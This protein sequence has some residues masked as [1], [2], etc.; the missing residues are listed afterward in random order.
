MER[1]VEE[2]RD[3]VAS[4]H[5]SRRGDLR[6]GGGG[7]RAVGSSSMPACRLKR[8]GGACQIGGA[9]LCPARMPR[10]HT[11]AGK[12]ALLPFTPKGLI[13]PT[14][15][16]LNKK[17]Q[18]PTRL[19]MHSLEEGPGDGHPLLLTA[20]QLEPALAHHCLPP[21]AR[22]RS[23]HSGPWQRQTRRETMK[24]G[25][26]IKYLNEHTNATL[27]NGTALALHDISSSTLLAS[28]SQCGAVTK[29]LCPTHR[30]THPGACVRWPR[31]AGRRRPPPAPP[32]SLR[33]AGRRPRCGKWCHGTARCP[34]G[35]RACACMCW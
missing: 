12:E 33:P 14:A 1:S 6:P 8:A 9:K 3:E 10:Q 2:S 20:T 27:Q 7:A 17:T 30:A 35:K 4:S 15:N 23:R 5:T 31:P 22:A 29:A 34:T 25:V 21:C 28:K 11:P 24:L 18:E 26:L 16:P 19:R 13:Q 32:Q